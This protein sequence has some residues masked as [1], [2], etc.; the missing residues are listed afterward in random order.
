MVG[1]CYRWLVGGTVAG[2]GGCEMR[3]DGK[4]GCGLRCTHERMIKPL[5]RGY[6][7][8]FPQHTLPRFRG[9]YPFGFLEIHSP[10]A[11]EKDSNFNTLGQQLTRACPHLEV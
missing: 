9:F 2:R 6:R 1:G 4:R 10:E 3:V 5:W 8:R 11:V 7:H